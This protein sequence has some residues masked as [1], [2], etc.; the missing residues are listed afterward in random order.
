MGHSFPVRCARS[1][2]MN[3]VLAAD[4]LPSC[5]CCGFGATPHQS[6]FWLGSERIALRLADPGLDQRQ[7]LIGYRSIRP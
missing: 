1:E 7:T 6:P 3:P 2:V 4:R 5:Y